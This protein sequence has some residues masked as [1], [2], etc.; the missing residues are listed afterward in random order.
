MPVHISS[1]LIPIR[2]VTFITKQHHSLLRSFVALI[3][4]KFFFVP[5]LS[6]SY[7]PFLA[8]PEDPDHQPRRHGRRRRR[9]RRG[10]DGDGATQ[11][12]GSAGQSAERA[13]L[14]A[15]CRQEPQT[16]AGED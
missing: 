15:C 7:K 14:Q 6:L 1:E 10:V 8:Q 16:G 12:A 4:S 11:R 9:G 2:V 13:G 3:I 5:N